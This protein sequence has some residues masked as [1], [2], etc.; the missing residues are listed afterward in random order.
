M[1]LG[2]KRTHFGDIISDGQRWQVFMAKEIA[3]FV[4]TQ[5][6]RIGKITVRLEEK[7]YTELLVPKDEWAHEQMTMSSLRLDTVIAAV[8]HI[9]RTRA[10]QLVESGKV[11]VNWV[12]NK[13]PDF[14]LD[15]LDIV[16]IRGFGR[17][18]IQAF[19]GKTKK[20]KCRLSLGVLR[21]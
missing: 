17:I 6:Q 13:H 10:K 8:Y 21:K 9:S 7:S 18:Q 3:Q 12:E 1:N 2:V 16:S 15:L 14:L 11:K 4:V 20:D 5:L 19:E